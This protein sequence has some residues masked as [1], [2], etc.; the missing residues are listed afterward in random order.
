MGMIEYS[1]VRNVC[2][3]GLGGIVG[4]SGEFNIGG[5]VCVVGVYVVCGRERMGDR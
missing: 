5:M 4:F 3:M 1:G 2:M